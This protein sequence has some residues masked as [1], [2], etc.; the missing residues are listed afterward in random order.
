[1]ER[2]FWICCPKCD[3]QFYCDYQ[4]RFKNIKLICPMCEDEFN[5]SEGLVLF[6]D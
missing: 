4:L 1:M 6:N 3:G 2:I 5:V